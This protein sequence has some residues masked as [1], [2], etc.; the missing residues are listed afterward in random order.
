M[1]KNSIYLKLRCVWIKILRMMCGSQKKSFTR[2]FRSDSFH[3]LNFNNSWGKTKDFATCFPILNIFKT[4]PQHSTAA[5]KNW[6]RIYQNFAW[7]VLKNIHP[8]PISLIWISQFKEYKERRYNSNCHKIL[9]YG[10]Q[11]YQNCIQ[12]KGKILMYKLSTKVFS[13]YNIWKYMKR[14]ILTL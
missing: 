9:L 7:K 14:K 8:F 2:Q 5:I 11:L 3:F 4:I 6:E 13:S 1:L 10:K 12:F